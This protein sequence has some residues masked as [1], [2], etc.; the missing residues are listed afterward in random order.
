MTRARTVQ[1]LLGMLTAA[2]LV[3]QLF[4]QGA[5][6]AQAHAAEPTGLKAQA[7]ACE[8]SPAPAKATEHH[9][10]TRNRLNPEGLPDPSA[11][12]DAP[13]PLAVPAIAAPDFSG[14]VRDGD[15]EA[16]GGRSAAALQVFRC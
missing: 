11:G 4:A 14:A 3:L 12:F 1:A 7:V 2:L 10:T 16:S 8:H 5:R 13:S 9:G 6:G 15:R